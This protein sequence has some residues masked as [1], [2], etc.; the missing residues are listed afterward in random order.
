MP[1]GLSAALTAAVPAATTAEPALDGVAGWAVNLMETLGP[2]GAAIAIALE[3]LF[4]PL[5][6]EIILPLA[7]FTASQGSFGLVEAILWTTAGSVV[8]ALALYAVGAIIGRERTRWIAERLPLV[9]VEDVDRT[10]QFFLR[11]GSA[12]VFFGRFIPIFRSLISIPAGV[13]RMPLWKFTAL[14]TAGSAVWNT[15]F[16]YAGY[17]LGEQWHV[18]EEYAGVLQKVVIAVVA[19]AVVWFV[20]TRVWRWV[21]DDERPAHARGRRDAAPARDEA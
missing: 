19:A 6:S 7:G 4:P 14:T 10:E 21:H 16:V 20:V 11:H 18:V 3:N 15:I 5:P 1:S 9:K 13:E 17:A 2:V 12:T 8:G